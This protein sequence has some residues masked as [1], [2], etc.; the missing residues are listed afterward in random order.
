MQE[1]I[2]AICVPEGAAYERISGGASGP[3]LTFA[4]LLGGL[5][6][7]VRIKGPLADIAFLVEL[8]I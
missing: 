7:N 5:A 2:A 4:C 3:V 6:A 1:V 8:W